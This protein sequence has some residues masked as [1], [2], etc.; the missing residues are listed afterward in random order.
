MRGRIPAPFMCG[1]PLGEPCVIHTAFRPH[2]YEMLFAANN[3][4]PTGGGPPMMRTPITILTG[5]IAVLT[6]F[7]AVPAL[8]DPAFAT[9]NVI[10]VPAPASPTKRST[11]S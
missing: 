8:A 6:A 2:L 9:R 4:E 3:E 10:S 5:A 7:Y 1:L 11:S